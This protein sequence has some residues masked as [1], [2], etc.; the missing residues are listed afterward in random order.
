MRNLN[1]TRAAAYAAALSAIAFAPFSAQAQTTGS[2]PDDVAALREQIRQLDQ[3]LRILERNLELKDEAAVAEAKKQPVVTAGAGGF[4]LASPDKKFSLRIRGNNQ[5]DGRHYFE[6]KSSTTDTPDAFVLRRVRPSFEGTVAEK[7]SFRVMPDFANNNV[8]LLDA[9]AAYKHTNWLTILAGKTKSPFDLERLVSQTNML[10][11]ERSLPTQL[12]PN[13]DTG[14]QFSGDLFSNRLTYQTAFLDGASD[15]NS[16]ETDTNDGK[17]IVLRLF[18]HP[19]KASEESLLKGLGFGVAYSQ[20]TREVGSG[21][22]RAFQTNSLINFFSY[23]S[24][25]R[26]DGDTTRFSPQLTY[27]KGP[28]GLNASYTVSEIE[29]INATTPAAAT[30]RRDLSTSAWAVN[31]NYVLTGEDTGYNTNPRPRQDFDW[32]KGTWGAWEVAARYSGL[33]VDDDAFTGPG[34]G[35]FANRNT[36]A[37]S[38][39]SWSLGLNWY[40]NRHVKASINL[41]HSSF[42]SAA[43]STADFD[44]EIALLSRVQLQF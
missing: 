32:S 33:S 39:E 7:F 36:Q 44:D 21:A 31:V 41:E 11:I 25:V 37:S 19:F 29:L 6:E 23:N 16:V 24:T 27:A 40:L 43:G 35:T 4:S 14:I 20:G 34:T 9:W 1:V 13:R 18:A 38:V 5:A 10:F 3:K 8:T 26:P 28:F 22:P 15:G 2:S 30:A 17:D 42:D 12:G